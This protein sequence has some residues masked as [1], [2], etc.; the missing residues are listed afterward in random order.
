M[1]IGDLIPRGHTA[2]RVREKEDLEP[3][4]T[5]NPDHIYIHSPQDIYM[6][7]FREM[8]PDRETFIALYLN[9]K[10]RVLKKEIVS[11]GS[12]NQNIV[13]P[14]EVYKDAVLLSAAS[15]ACAHNHPSGDPTP[16]REDLDLTERL[17]KA[18]EII[19]ISLLDHVI[20]GGEGQ[21]YSMKERG[22]LR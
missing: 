4:Y 5:K 3:Y 9:T 10:N 15:V 19:G 11:F 12:I 8:Y 6:Q 22:N 17:Y 14:R 16:S 20:I 18:G 21:Y 1:L 7:V 2:Y 13:H